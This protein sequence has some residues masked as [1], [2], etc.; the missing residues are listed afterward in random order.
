MGQR[1][2]LKLEIGILDGLLRQWNGFLKNIISRIVAR[3]CES[4]L[5]FKIFEYFCPFLSLTIVTGQQGFLCLAERL[6]E[7]IPESKNLNIF[8]TAICENFSS[9]FCA[10]SFL[11]D[12]VTNKA[13]KLNCSFESHHGKNS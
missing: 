7:K 12:L 5:F 9:E 2:F 6:D 11:C 8:F 13:R 4:L 3:F 10:F 1:N